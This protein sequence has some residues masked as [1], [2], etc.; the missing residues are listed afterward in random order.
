[1]RR[2]SNKHQK[3]H[4]NLRAQAL[5]EFAL[6]LPLLLVLI[7]GAMDLGRVFYFKIILTN[8]A[9]EGANYL[10]RNPADYNNTLNAIITEG[11]SSGVTI[12]AGEV[13]WAGCCT[14][15]SPVVITIDKDVD[16]IFDGFL[17]AMGIIDGP[18]TIS[19]SVTMV[20]QP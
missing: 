4:I 14:V 15:G 5:V 7:L 20:V 8:A 3:Q 12:T 1:M 9:R 18:V 11:D 6:L 19:S 17:N 13:T 10:S 2:R 16:L